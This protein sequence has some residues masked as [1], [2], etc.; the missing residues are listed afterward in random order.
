MKPSDHLVE[1]HFRLSTLRP[2]LGQPISVIFEYRNS[3]DGP[4][5]FSIGNSREDGFR[6]NTTAPGVKALNPYNEM[7][8]IAPIIHLAP[9]QSGRQEIRLDEYLLFTAPGEHIIDAELD[10]AVRDEQSV[11]IGREKIRDRFVVSIVT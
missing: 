4:V 6:F 11:I 3:S 5:T 2:L 9:G 7:G 10:L 1:G 8:G